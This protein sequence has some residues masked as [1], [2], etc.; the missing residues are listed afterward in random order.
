MLTQK[1]KNLLALSFFV[2]SLVVGSVIRFKD[3]FNLG[4]VFD[5]IT[6][7]YTWA[8]EVVRLDLVTMWRSYTEF[9]DY[10]LL[11]LTFVSL[12]ETVSRFFGGGQESFVAGLKLVYWLADIALLLTLF[13][14]F[15]RNGI[16]KIMSYISL[17]L[18]YILPG[19]W[20]VS[21]VWGQSDTLHALLV[22]WSLQLLY[23]SKLNNVIW[24]GILFGIALQFKLQVLLVLI[25]I[26]LYYVAVYKKTLLTV[27]KPLLV[28]FVLSSIVSGLSSLLLVLE[29]R[30][31]FTYGDGWYKLISVYNPYVL[32]VSLGVMVLPM[33]LTIRMFGLSKIKDQFEKIHTFLAS[34]F[35]ITVFGFGIICFINPLRFTAAV[36]QPLTTP[37]EFSGSANLS[38][39]WVKFVETY[40][41]TNYKSLGKY[42]IIGIFITLL[43]LWF[44][45]NYKYAKN[46]F[47]NLIFSLSQF[48]LLYYILSTGR[49]HS[50]YGHFAIVFLLLLIPFIKTKVRYWIALGGIFLF[51]S[52]NQ[53]LVYFDTPTNPNSWAKQLLGYLSQQQYLFV[54]LGMVV[55]SL[56]WYYGFIKGEI[57]LTEDTEGSKLNHA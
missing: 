20:F 14:L 22:I 17:G 38:N 56:I 47:L 11:N 25:G 6:T 2:V 41:I 8:T 44:R 13:K 45:Y 29:F 43:L 57:V 39:G 31:N 49:V 37:Y 3:L 40:E 26:I 4:Y 30:K 35:V 12:I 5:T 36:I 24:G 10:P 51:Y 32:L 52:V 21:G 48:V 28:G 23:S 15:K 16:S 9:L 54:V 33:Y 55:S 18:V 53:L 7:Q 42:L 34:F 46:T 27:W 1:I 19:L 50:R